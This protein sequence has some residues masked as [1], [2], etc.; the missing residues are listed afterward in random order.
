MSQNLPLF[1]YFFDLLARF[2]SD[3]TTFHH[4]FEESF[5][6]I[7]NFS[8]GIEKKGKEERERKNV[9]YNMREDRFLFENLI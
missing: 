2:E 8:R 7:P 5:K 1:P 3:S 9:I 6:L 4:F